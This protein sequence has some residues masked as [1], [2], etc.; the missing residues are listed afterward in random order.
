M[1]SLSISFKKLFI[2]QSVRRYDFF[3]VYD[4]TYESG[5]CMMTYD[6]SRGDV[7]YQWS[8]KTATFWWETD[9]SNTGSDMTAY[10][11]F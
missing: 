7:S 5:T 3:D 6:G 8:G 9:E 1:L 2:F 4:G 11:N 10:I